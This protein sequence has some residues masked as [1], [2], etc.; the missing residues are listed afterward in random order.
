MPN[1]ENQ[2]REYDVVKGGQDRPPIDAAVLGGIQGVKSRLASSVFAVRIAALSEAMKY[3]DAGLD[4]VVSALQDDSMQK[5]W[6]LRSITDTHHIYENLKCQQILSIPAHRDR[7]WKFGTLRALMAKIAQQSGDVAA[8]FS[9]TY[10]CQDDRERTPVRFTAIVD[11]TFW[12]V[13]TPESARQ[14]SYHPVPW[15]FCADGTVS[16]SNLWRGI[17]Q[18]IDLEEWSI[19]VTIVHQNGSTDCFS[20]VFRPYEQSFTAFKEGAEY[21]IGKK[22]VY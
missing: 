14:G 17:W 21:R 19:R 4:L 10:E 11:N 9:G 18:K 22:I 12:Q 13:N 2:P 5:S 20:V 6:F 7:D 8:N 3:G 1:P 16:A 15:K